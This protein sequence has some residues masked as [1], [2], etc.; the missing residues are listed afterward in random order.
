MSQQNGHSDAHSTPQKFLQ[1]VGFRNPN[2]GASV[3]R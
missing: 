3:K 1:L 2:T